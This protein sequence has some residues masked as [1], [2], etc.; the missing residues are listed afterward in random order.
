MGL[1][2]VA[3]AVKLIV[4]DGYASEVVIGLIV[5]GTP[6]GANVIGSLNALLYP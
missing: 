2:L 3:G 4:T 6:D 1:P 5:A